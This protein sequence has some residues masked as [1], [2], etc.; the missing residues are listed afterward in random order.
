MTDWEP[1]KLRKSVGVVA[2]PA[3][4]TIECS[5]QVA[6]EPNAGL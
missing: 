3:V 2:V 1:Y 5:P 6:L 4:A